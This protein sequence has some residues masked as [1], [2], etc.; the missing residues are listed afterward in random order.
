[1]ESEGIK[2]KA[3]IARQISLDKGIGRT[4]FSGSHKR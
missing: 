3:E 1:M 2:E 4:N